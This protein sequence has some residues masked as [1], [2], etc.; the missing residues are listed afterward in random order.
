MVKRNVFQWSQIIVGFSLCI[1]WLTQSGC[2][3]GGE[4]MSQKKRT[5]PD[6]FFLEA[7]D[8]GSSDPKD[9]RVVYY[10]IFLD[11]EIAAKTSSGL[12]Y[13][14]KKTSLYLAPGRYLFY[15]ERWYLEEAGESSDIAEYKR[16]NN[17]WQMKP[18]YI[19]VAEDT[20]KIKFTFGFDHDKQEF[21]YNMESET[22]DKN[23]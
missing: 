14:K 4:N 21:Y 12:F 15:A 8:K 20:K 9:D 23:R 7:V 2:V 10:K 19:D 11:K 5:M 18:M 17:V 22:E 6:N 3:S 16:A 1:L 13:Q